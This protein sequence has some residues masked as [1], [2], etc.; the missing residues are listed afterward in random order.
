[1]I[2]SEFAQAF[3]CPVL[4]EST[5]VFCKPVEAEAPITPSS[6]GRRDVVQKA[7]RELY[8]IG[9]TLTGDLAAEQFAAAARQTE[10]RART[11]LG[12][13]GSRALVS[14]LDDHSKE[15]IRR[16]GLRCLIAEFNGAIFSVEWEEVPWSK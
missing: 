9:V 3:H 15:W 13:D 1:V 10:A 8:A 16:F 12:L 11:F 5:R 2:V 14:P 7:V 6:H 4:G